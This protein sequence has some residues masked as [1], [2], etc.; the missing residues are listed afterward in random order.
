MGCVKG[1]DY[2]F[3]VPELLSM[4]YATQRWGGK[5]GRGSVQDHMATLQWVL[6]PKL[7]RYRFYGTC[8]PPTASIP[9]MTFSQEEAFSRSCW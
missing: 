9:I 2:R 6:I 1:L 5:E 8:H 7:P 4:Y 3:E